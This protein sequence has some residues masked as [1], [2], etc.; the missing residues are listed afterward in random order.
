MAHPY[1][2]NPRLFPTHAGSSSFRSAMRAMAALV[3]CIG[4]LGSAACT[5]N[6]VTGKTQ[7]DFMGEN[8]EVQ[9]GK[10]LYPRYTQQ[11]LGEVPDPRLEAYVDR[12]GLKLARVSQ[13]PQLPW[14]YNAVNDP[15]VNAYALPGGKISIT[16]GLLSRLDNE[17]ELAAV[18]GHETGHVNARHAAQA[19]T[20]QVLAQ[21]A[22]LGAGIY[23]DAHGTR[24]AR[25]Y[26]VAGMLG[27]QLMFAHYSRNQERQA[28]QLGFEYMTKA[29]YN[30]E[31]MVGVMRILLHEGKTRP[32]LLRRMFADHPMSSER[33]ATAEARVAAEPP[34]VRTRPIRSQRFL[35]AV[36]H[37]RETRPAYD[38][39]AKAR[40]LLAQEKTAEAETLLKESVAEWPDDGLLRGYLAGAEAE[41]GKLERAMR[42]AQ[43]A[44]QDAP[45]IFVV[46]MLAGKIFLRAKRYAAAVPF[47]DNAS[48]ILPNLPEV[49][50]LRGEA[51]EGAG[52][53]KEAARAYQ[54]VRELAPG[55][56]ASA[57]ASRRL[58][59]LGMTAAG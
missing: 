44:G 30:P 54:R 27:M 34:A 57:E 59:S 5:V 29:G 42:D 20:R 36:R 10:N 37:I 50:L 53:R 6:P 43:R 21:L 32:S 19:Y 15:E 51:L 25:L 56:D 46:Q 23:M 48:R 9:L 16:R 11:S 7:L 18:L 24:N 58:R 2:V 1:V 26:T 12:V 39:F 33:L 38:R 22:L 49:E 40:R 45:H 28:D 35:A 17:D 14:T 55:S 4:M 52:R 31:G 47:F 41:D 3:L 8:Q 13:R